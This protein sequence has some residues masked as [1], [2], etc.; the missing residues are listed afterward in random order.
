MDNYNLTEADDILDYFDI[1]R[2]T[3]IVNDQIIHATDYSTCG[4][5]IDYLKPLYA[6]YKEIHPDIENNIDAVK[7]GDCTE[8]FNII[9]M[10]FADAICNKFNV[11]IDDLWLE[12]ASD[13]DKFLLT[14]YLYSF[15]V[16]DFKTVMTDICINYID[17]NY[18]TIGDM[19]DSEKT[20]KSATYNALL[21]ITDNSKL[22]IIGSN[23]FDAIYYILD[24]LTMESMFEYMPEDYLPMNELKEYF[25]NGTVGGDIYSRIL[26]YIKEN[27]TLRSSMAFDII[28]YIRTE[29]K[30]NKTE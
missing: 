14:L 2:M 27:S 1:D 23:I 19:L 15:L 3:E 22:A 6:K 9:V 17:K 4:V 25:E 8:K 21:T 12:T 30:V 26:G 13:D 18:D 11:D 16:I 10:M 29:Y 5:V 20:Q 7:Y 24:N 28:S